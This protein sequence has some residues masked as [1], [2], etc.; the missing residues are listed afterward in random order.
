MLLSMLHGAAC[1][2]IIIMLNAFYCPIYAQNYAG[3]IGPSLD[4][5]TPYMN[6]SLMPSISFGYPYWLGNCYIHGYHI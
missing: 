2:G 1:L 3:I 6:C 5:S 4:Q